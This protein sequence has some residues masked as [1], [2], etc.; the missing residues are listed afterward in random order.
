MRKTNNLQ[1]T[2]KVYLFRW[3]GY[4]KPS[5]LQ[6]TC[7]KRAVYSFVEADYRRNHKHNNYLYQ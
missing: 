7:R 2:K 6:I 4:Q 1:K 3:S 5:V